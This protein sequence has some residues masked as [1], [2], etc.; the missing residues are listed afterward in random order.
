MDCLGESERKR[1]KRT[2]VQATVRPEIRVHQQAPVRINRIER[3]KAN[4]KLAKSQTHSYSRIQRGYFLGKSLQVSPP[5]Q[6][7]F[8]HFLLFLAKH[9]NEFEFCWKG[10]F[11]GGNQSA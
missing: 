10:G 9:L 3:P 7:K 5:G 11:T 4:Q 2:G 1:E 8:W 6:R